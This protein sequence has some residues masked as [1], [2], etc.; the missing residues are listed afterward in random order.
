MDLGIRVFF[1]RTTRTALGLAVAA[2][3]LAGC[4]PGAGDASSTPSP[5]PTETVTASP[6][7]TPTPTPTAEAGPFVIDCQSIIPQSR[8]DWVN[9][10]GWP[11]FAPADFFAKVR[12]EVSASPYILMQDNGGIV[13]PYTVGFE[14]TLAYG[15]APLADSQVA[16]ADAL[17]QAMGDLHT[18]SSYAGGTLYTSG[19][20]GNAFQHFLIIPGRMF[21]ST[22]LEILDEM[23]ATVP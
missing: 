11:L 18:L 23:V 16:E 21:V 17:I 2:L 5:T 22:T 1:M 8:R 10:S 12:S 3:L 20:E 4:T 6:T 13:C 7:P 14:V 19:I 9:S 15:Y